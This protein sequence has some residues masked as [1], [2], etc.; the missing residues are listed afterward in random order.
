MRPSA[1]HINLAAKIAPHTNTPLYQ[2]ET[3]RSRPASNPKTQG[4]QHR[5]ELSNTYQVN[6]LREVKHY[7]IDNISLVNQLSDVQQQ[8]IL[9]SEVILK[10]ILIR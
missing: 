5:Q 8:L 9:T 4:F 3:I 6:Y 1:C 2:Q 7:C 10:I